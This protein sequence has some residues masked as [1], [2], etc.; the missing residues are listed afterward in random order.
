MSGVKITSADRVFS[1][2]IRLRDGA[3][4]K[5]CGS[6]PQAPFLECAHHFTRGIK[7]TRFDPDNA[8]A[9]CRRC[10][11]DMDTHPIAKEAFWRSVI[12]DDRFEALAARAHGRRDRVGVTPIHT[13]P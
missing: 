9:L 11:E 5:R 1:L 12:G 7:A 8:L 2:Q 10:H 4:C 3:K 6:V 13:D